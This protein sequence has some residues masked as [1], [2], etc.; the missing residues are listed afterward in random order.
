V[1]LELGQFVKEIRS[2]WK[3]LK[4]GAGKERRRSIGTIVRGIGKFYMD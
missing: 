1:E 2:T 3:H 4:R